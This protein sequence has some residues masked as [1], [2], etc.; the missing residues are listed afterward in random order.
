MGSWSVRIPIASEMA[1]ATAPIGGTNDTSPTLDIV[2]DW[3]DTNAAPPLTNDAS[4]N[5]DSNT[6]PDDTSTAD[7]LDTLTDDA[8]LD[9]SHVIPTSVPSGLPVA[10]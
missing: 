5:D 7:A 6:R 1:L 10:D 8:A 9:L 4:D 2:A 3:L